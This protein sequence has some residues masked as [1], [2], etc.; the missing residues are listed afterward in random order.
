MLGTSSTAAASN[1]QTVLSVNQSG[2]NATSTQS[3]YGIKISNK[4]TGT[5]STNIG[6]D[7]DVSGAWYNNAINVTSG[8]VLLNNNSLVFGPNSNMWEFNSS[9]RTNANTIQNSAIKKCIFSEIQI[10]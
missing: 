1:L 3:T 5:A 10:K 6:I 8:S 7:L 4:K 2:A 9:L